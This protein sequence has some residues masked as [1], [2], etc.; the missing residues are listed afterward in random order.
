[1][2]A[3]EPIAEA[4][5]A[6]NFI[7]APGLDAFVVRGQQPPAYANPMACVTG[8]CTVCDPTWIVYGE[9]L[10]LRPGNDKVAF[11]VPIDG[12]I[13]PPAGAPP[14]QVGPEA[15]VDPS[16]APGVRVG[17]ER[18]YECCSAIG[19]QFTWYESTRTDDVVVTP[20]I[21]L[22]S[23]VNH[24]GSL[25]AATDSLAATATS[26]IEFELG[27]VFYRRYLIRDENCD[28]SLI[29]GARYVHL[30]EAF[31]ST[32]TSAA[33]VETVDTDI[34][35][36]GGGI[37]LG[38]EA[39]QRAHYSGLMVYGKGYA[40]FVGG[41]F[42]GRYVQADAQRGVVVNTGWT[43]DRAISILDAEVGIGWIT[44]RG[45]RITGGYMFSGWFNVINTDAFIRAVRKLDSVNVYDSLSFDG[46]VA[47][48]E[49]RF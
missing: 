40:S 23:L 27:D 49:A 12:A 39:E 19:G 9:F 7:T 22:R 11:A 41:Q 14:V 8:A 26:R 13:V 44:G 46:F 25:S 3:D 34:S 48:L 30:E 31:R 17:L 20:P 29:G 47:R 1:V 16:F 45:L 2:V 4:G 24:P 5:F 18:A 42:V 33:T 10:Y 15:V 36:D 32:F 38:L 37:R 43:E 28:V 21:V 35:F 6:K